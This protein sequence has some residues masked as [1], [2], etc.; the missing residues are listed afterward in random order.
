MDNFIF[1]EKSIIK[2]YCKWKSFLPSESKKSAVESVFIWVVVSG[3]D[4]ISDSYLSIVDNSKW[5]N[6]PWRL[7][8]VNCPSLDPNHTILQ[9]W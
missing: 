2:V 1:M 9:T 7:E 8:I 6:G 4:S 5:N 3:D